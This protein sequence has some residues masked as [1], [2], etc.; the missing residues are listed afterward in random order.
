MLAAALLPPVAVAQSWLDYDQT[1]SRH[2]WLRTSNAAALTTYQPADS[3]QRWLGDASVSLST[4]QGWLVEPGQSPHAWQ[5]GAQARSLCRLSRRVVLRGGIDYSYGWGSDASGSVWIS[6]ERMPMDIAEVSDTTRGTVALERYG[7]TG[8]VGVQTLPGLSVGA[9]MSYGAGSYTKR[10]DPRHTNSLMLIDAT[11]GVTW[12][13]AGLTL[14]A[15]YL[16]QRSTEALRFSTYGRTDRVYHYLIDFG[17]GM[18]RTEQ[19]DGK[20]YVSSDYEKP[21]LDMRHGVAVQAGYEHGPWSAVAEWHWARRHGH[22]GLESPSLLDCNRHHGHE[23]HLRSWWQ[24]ATPQAIHRLTALWSHEDVRDSERT[25]RI[26]TEGGVTHID[27]Y[28]DREMSQRQADHVSVT[29]DGQW[30][31]ERHLATWQVQACVDYRLRTITASLFPYYRWQQTHY[32][33]LT[34]EARRNGLTPGGHTWSVG[35]LA[36]CGSGG[37]TTA[38]DGAYTV[39]ADGATFPATDEAWLMRHYEWLT[40]TRLQ[41][42]VTLR[43]SMPLPR[44]RL[45]AQ[46]SYSLAHAFDTHWLADAYRHTATLALGCLF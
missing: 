23:W 36:R 6:P 22:Y 20:G 33:A 37:G 41:G 27:Y 43:W 15:N 4:G 3:S 5:L 25:Y 7:L 46:G 28:D 42:G 11:A 40:A 21:L 10:R 12:Q 18:G 29:Y 13:R 2:S 39:P 34:L 17:A 30:G 24:R 32:T 35:V 38:S 8:E 9:R 31:I 16:L 26:V 45:Y 14:G 44:L 1:L 19:T